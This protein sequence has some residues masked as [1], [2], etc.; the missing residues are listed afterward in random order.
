[1]LADNEKQ[2]NAAEDIVNAKVTDVE[3]ILEA[4]EKDIA[5]KKAEK[6]DEKK[7]DSS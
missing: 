5:K 2:V 3:S 1:M 4:D 6:K 7:D